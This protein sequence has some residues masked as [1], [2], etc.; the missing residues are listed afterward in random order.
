MIPIISKF[1]S[2]RLESLHFNSIDL[3]YSHKFSTVD[4]SNIELARPIGSTL[5]I[6]NEDPRLKYKAQ[7]YGSDT[8]DAQLGGI[9]QL[10]NSVA[11][12]GFH[13]AFPTWFPK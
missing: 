1:S 13:L 9:D 8:L 2:N 11:Q 3:L 10:P 12:L 4:L 7:K 5:E 6:F